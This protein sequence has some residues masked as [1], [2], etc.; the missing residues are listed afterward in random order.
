L[1]LTSRPS[2]IFFPH[3]C[4][5]SLDQVKVPWRRWLSA[6]LK[7]ISMLGQGS[8]NYD[9]S[10]LYTLLIISLAA[11]FVWKLSEYRTFD[12][13]TRFFEL[14]DYSNIEY[15]NGKWRKV[16][17]YRILDTGTKL[18]LSDYQI[19]AIKL[20]IAQLRFFKY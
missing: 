6:R 16:S 4:L 13:W 1:D 18:K 17:D 9:R 15:W 14:S 8:T 12:Y 2:K 3:I 20:S 10:L 5:I 7:I 11:K 19:S